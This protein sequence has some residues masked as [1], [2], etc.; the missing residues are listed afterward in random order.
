MVLGVF[1]CVGSKGGGGHSRSLVGSNLVEKWCQWL[2]V[3][4]LVLVSD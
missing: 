3:V 1:G 2:T 4:P